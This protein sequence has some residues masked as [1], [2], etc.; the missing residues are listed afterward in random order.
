MN[1]YLQLIINR[2]T[3]SNFKCKYQADTK[4]D[5]V[6]SAIK[7]DIYRIKSLILLVP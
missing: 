6:H 4:Q 3:S 5:L 7:V 2:T 1:A